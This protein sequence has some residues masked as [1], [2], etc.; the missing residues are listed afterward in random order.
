MGL[1][2]I[3]RKRLNIEYC[4]L[5]ASY[6]GIVC[7]ISGG[8]ASVFLLS[9]GFSN[10]QVGIIVAIGN[11]L[12]VAL[13][14][15]LANL[16]DQGRYISLHNLCILLAVSIVAG[17]GLLFFIRSVL[18]ATGIVFAITFAL[19]QILQTLSNSVSL[20][21]INEGVEVNFGLARGMGSAFYALVSSLV[22]FWSNKF[23]ANILLLVGVLLLAVFIVVLLRMPKLSR[24]TEHKQK[25]K[26]G[27]AKDRSVWGFLLKYKSFLVVLVGVTLIFIFH[28]ICN[29]YL[30]QLLQR[31]GG[32]SKSM[33]TALSIAAIVEL[34][35]ML[36]FS[37]VSKRINSR[38]L[39]IL[40]GCMFFLKAVAFL[41]AHS[42]LQMYLC[43]ILQMGGYGLFI[44]AS[45]FYVNEL[46]DK[47]DM[48]KGQALMV[49]ACTLGGVFASL[50]GGVIIDSFGIMYLLGFQTVCAGVG[51]ACLFFAPKIS[52]S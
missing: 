13:Q 19:V 27:D 9:K 1:E 16:A 28:S 31:V 7:V 6:W 11:I 32:D 37:K 17:C 4:I 8:F 33:G 43:Q 41:L 29:V 18:L 46:V 25:T 35:I 26:E 42:V 39:L 38:S 45:V 51:A 22:G 24:K 47:E 15:F 49:S 21:Y 44:P 3:S 50:L 48:V 23:G 10:T 36:I 40:S 12:G 52:Y 2:Q 5:L 20:Y 30:F 34:P 14:P